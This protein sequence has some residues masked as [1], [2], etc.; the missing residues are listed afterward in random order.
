[1]SLNSDFI[2]HGHPH[3]FLPDRLET[4]NKISLFYSKT[5]ILH[6]QNKITSK[7]MSPTK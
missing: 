7:F 5:I 2:L 1:M 3:S 6:T 4:S